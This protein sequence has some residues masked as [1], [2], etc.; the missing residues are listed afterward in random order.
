MTIQEINRAYHRIIGALDR[1]ELKNAFVFLHSLLAGLQAYSLQE[2][3][4]TLQ[5]TYTFMLKYRL[6]GAKDPMEQQ[7]YSSLLTQTYELCDLARHR[8]LEPV[9]PLTYYNKRRI[10]QANPPQSYSRLY[11]TLSI[12]TDTIEDKK[13]FEAAQVVLFNRL[14][15]AEPI[16]KDDILSVKEILFDPALPHTVGCQIVSALFLSLQMSFDKERLLLL[17]DALH[18]ENEEIHIRALVSILLVLYIYRKRI[19]LYPQINDRLAAIHESRPALTNDI[20]TV[21]LRFIL[22]RE[23]EKI[24][25]KLQEEIIPEMMKLTPKINKKM[26]LRDPHLELPGDEM[27]PEWQEILSEGDLGKKMQEF[28]ELQQE[29]ADVMHSTFIHLKSFPFFREVGNWFLPFTI[30]YSDLAAHFGNGNK[31]IRMLDSMTTASFMCNS[32]K[33]SLYFSMMQMPEEHRNMMMNQF[34]GQAEEMLEQNKEELFTRRQKTEIIV[35]QYVQDL[36]RFFKLYPGRID[37]DDIFKQPLDFHN[38]KALQP[39]IAETES[40]TVI[41]EYYLRKK[42][43]E[44]ALPI[45]EQLAEREP[46]NEILFQKIGFCKQMEGEVEGAIEAYLRADLLNSSSKWVIRRIAACYRTL[47]QPDEALKYYRRYEA[48]NPD[49]LSLLMNIGHCL[50]ELK[51][52]AEALKYYFKVDYLDTKGN[53]AWRP[54]AWCSFL[55]G[56]FDQARHYYKKILDNQPNTQ[57]YL[58]AGH[59]EWVLQNLGKAVEFYKMAVVKEEGNFQKFNEQFNQDIHDLLTAGIEECEIPLMLDQVRYSLEELI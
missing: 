10:F 38:L 49:D 26:N 57:D 43:Y 44:D 47:K 37:F 51:E 56:K 11:A 35:G 21:I 28:T 4:Q 34:T 32:D 42:Y 24:T 33:Y 48:M 9:S 20:R 39:Y 17:F 6:Q 18:T 16:N 7:I 3:L 36:Y 46:D 19:D 40:L 8:A 29:G 23:T 1:K 15:V 55:T 5:D 53:K 58:N 52:Y 30:D 13:R 31:A 50:L 54:I 45:Y 25:R 22:S 2:K 41:A 59:T 14:W 12:P 27:N